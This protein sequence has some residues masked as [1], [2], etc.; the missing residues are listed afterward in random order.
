MTQSI[1]FL[2]NVEQIMKTRVV[3]VSI[4]QSVRESRTIV[5]RNN[6]DPVAVVDVN[7]NL[8]G[9]ITWTDVLTNEPTTAGKLASHPRMTVGPHES[10]FSVISRMLSRRVDWVPVI[11]NRKLV[12]T[13]SRRCIMSAFGELHRA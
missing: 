1:Q 8:I 12:G 10:A 11:A 6:G 3:A 5:E 13:I 7:D 4:N 2:S 9:V